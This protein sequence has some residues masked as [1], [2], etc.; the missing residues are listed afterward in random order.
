MPKVMSLS[1]SKV[2]SQSRT[3][4]WTRTLKCW[5]IAHEPKVQFQCVFGSRLWKRLART[6]DRHLYLYTF[7]VV[8]PF[9]FICCKK[10]TARQRPNQV[11]SH[12]RMMTAIL[13]LAC[14]TAWVTKF[15]AVHGNALQD[16][17]Y[18]H[19]ATR[20][21]CA[22]DCIRIWSGLFSE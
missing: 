14:A 2:V 16:L 13:M 3:Q 22:Y 12:C 9:A 1:L 11:C 5:G 17:L 8:L 10:V 18:N 7:I 21:F 19:I 4:D 20:C 15:L 6:R